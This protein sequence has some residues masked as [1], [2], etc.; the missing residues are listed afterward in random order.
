MILWGKIAPPRGSYVLNCF[1]VSKIREVNIEVL[2]FLIYREGNIKIYITLK[3]IIISVLL[4]D[5][6]LW[7]V[8]QMS[9]VEVSF[10]DQKHMFLLT[11]IKIVNK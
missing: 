11:V 3:I 9:L 6:C 8:K 5:I 7:C 10:T 4:L 1:T 2:N